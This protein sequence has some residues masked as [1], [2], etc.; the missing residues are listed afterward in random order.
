MIIENILFKIINAFYKIHFKN[1]INYCNIF[2]IL[3]FMTKKFMRSI[4]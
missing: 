2:Y 1:W 3:Y 4:S